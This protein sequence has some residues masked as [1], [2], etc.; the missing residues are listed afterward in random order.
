MYVSTVHSYVMIRIDGPGRGDLT[1][2]KFGERKYDVF[3][4]VGI[5]YSFLI[6]KDSILGK[7]HEGFFELFKNVPS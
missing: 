4:V 1:F 7:L 3:H 5:K 2:T 6:I